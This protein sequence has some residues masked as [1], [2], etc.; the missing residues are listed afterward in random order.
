MT[1]LAAVF[2]IP[3]PVFGMIHLASLPGAPR[4]G[5]SVAAVLER[6]VR[7]AR[8]LKEA[9]VDA[10]VVENFNDEP[11]FTE[12]TAPETVAA[13]T[14][15][16]HAV[17]GAT[18]LPLGI[19]VLRNA[20]KAAMGIAAVVGARF[21]RINI[22]TDVYITDQGMIQGEAASLLRYRH[23]LGADDV[24]IFAD[25]YSKH[26]APLVHR[27]LE[28][29]AHDMVERGGADALLVSGHSSAHPPSLDDIQL[30]RDAVPGTPL[31]IGSGMSIDTV[32]MLNYV[33][34]TIFG[35]GAK[36]NLKDPVDPRRARAF[37]DAVRTLR[38]GQ[39]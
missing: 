31:I 10:L 30:L 13:I 6:A 36:A 37:M 1:G 20:W 17:R 34:A 32:E 24:L 21:V 33:D 12:T 18:G 28:V 4:Y 29:V 11:F 15:A 35:F 19:N 25:I 9:G 22:L 38:S 16:A 2:G 27:P 7:D 39:A 3:K 5:G 8:A 14:L 23:G 26:A